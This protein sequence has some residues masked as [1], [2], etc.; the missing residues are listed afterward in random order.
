MDTDQHGLTP[1]QMAQSSGVSIDTLRYYE[2]EGLLNAVAR[3]GNGHRRYSPD[4]VA[5]VEVLRCP[6]GHRHVHRA[7]AP[8]LRAWG[9]GQAYR[10]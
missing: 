8:V 3:A 10:A 9:A 4:D 5:W 6:A 1:A 2:R 7:A